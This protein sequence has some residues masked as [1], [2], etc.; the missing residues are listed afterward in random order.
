MSNLIEEKFE[1]MGARAIVGPNESTRFNSEPQPI[2][3]NILNDSEGTY[4]SIKHADD[5]EISI[6]DIKPKDRHL[7]LMAKYGGHHKIKSKFLCGHDERDWFV[8]AIPEDSPT[9]DIVSAMEALKPREIR[10][11]QRNMGIKTKN[12]NKRKNDAYK[13]QGEWFFIPEPDFEIKDYIIHKKESLIRGRGNPHIA[14]ELC[15]FGGSDI[16]VSR[17]EPNG[18]SV[19]EYEKRLKEPK[20]NSAAWSQQKKDMAVYVRGTIKHSDHATIYLDFWHKVIPNT[21]AKARAMR[22]VSFID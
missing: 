19:E 9:K 4:F 21:E 13:R 18:I 12:K 10:E 16:Y 20:F 1:K 14:A 15:R 3:L 8:A 7:L 11:L 2:D 22:N 6:L 5:V 17:S